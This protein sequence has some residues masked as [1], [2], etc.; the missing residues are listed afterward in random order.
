M[1]KTNYISD[2]T[3]DQPWSRDM[4]QVQ[5]LIAGEKE[6]KKKLKELKKKIAKKIK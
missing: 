5:I 6:A 4:G 3:E 2:I 1:K